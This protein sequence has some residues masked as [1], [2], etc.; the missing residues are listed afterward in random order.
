MPRAKSPPRADQT[1]LGLQSP[2]ERLRAAIALHDQLLV[3]VERRRKV[4]KMGVVLPAANMTLEEDATPYENDDQHYSVVP[5]IAK[6]EE[7]K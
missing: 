1:A 7:K 4:I 3:R 2:P 6:E 5:Y